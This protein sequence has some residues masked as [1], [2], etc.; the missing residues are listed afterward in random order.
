MDGACKEDSD[1][2]RGAPSAGRNLSEPESTAA[3]PLTATALQPASAPQAASAPQLASMPLLEWLRGLDHAA[4]AL[5][6]YEPGSSAP[7]SEERAATLMCA[8]APSHSGHR[9]LA[10]PSN[11]RASYWRPTEL[12]EIEIVAIIATL[13]PTLAVAWMARRAGISATPLQLILVS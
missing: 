6:Q 9:H 10:F 11:G 13:A 12:L 8:V 3:A 4:G 2:N 7:A 1:C 5:V